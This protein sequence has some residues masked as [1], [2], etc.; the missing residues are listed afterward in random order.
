MNNKKICLSCMEKHEEKIIIRTEKI[1]F[2]EKDVTFSAKYYYCDNTKEYWADEEMIRYNDI[3]MKDA[4]R[5]AM[6]LLTTKDIISIRNQY[7][8][9]QAD[10]CHILGWGA[11]TIARYETHQI[12]SR[13]HD[14]V[15]RK[16]GTDPKWFL[17]LLSIAQHNISQ[18][19]YAIYKENAE[20]E[21]SKKEKKLLKSVSYQIKKIANHITKLNPMQR[22]SVI[23]IP[24]REHK[25]REILR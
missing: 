8:V 6:N 21:Y 24:N 20:N 3:A 10:F 11:K 12:Q 13:A 4:Y 16:I 7:K 22:K 19:N 17:E 25:L 2:K 1:S 18:R 5:Q 15:L 9:T 23:S 14:N